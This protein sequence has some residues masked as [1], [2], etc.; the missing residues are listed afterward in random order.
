MDDWENFNEASSSQ[1]EDLNHLHMHD[2]TDADYTHA[3]RVCKD[4]E[5]KNLVEYHDFYVQSD[6]LLLADVFNNFQNMSWNIWAWSCSFSSAQGLP[7]Q[8][9]LKKTK[10]KLDFLTDID[11]LLIAEKGIRGG[12]CY[13]IYR[14]AKANK[15]HIKD[16]D[17]N[18]E[19]SYLKYWFI[20][21][22]YGWAMS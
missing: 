2:V 7:W 3:K 5:I 14:Y 4:F 22:L 8:T 1:K 12:M 19:S 20:N 16:Y 6:I 18:K 17:K 11:L 9:A 21:K 13:A 10:V 15:K